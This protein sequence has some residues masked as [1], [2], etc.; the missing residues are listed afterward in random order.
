MRGDICSRY[1][2]ISHRCAKIGADADYAEIDNSNVPEKSPLPFLL[3]ITSITPLLPCSSSTVPAL[4]TP[5]IESETVETV[6]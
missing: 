2:G 4:A 6:V 1:C 3:P 5:R